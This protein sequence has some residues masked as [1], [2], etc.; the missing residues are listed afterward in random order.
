M[1][2][3]DNLMSLSIRLIRQTP[4]LIW[5]EAFDAW[6]STLCRD[7]R[8]GRQAQVGRMRAQDRVLR[9][10]R[11]R[12]N[13]ATVTSIHLLLDNLQHL[14]QRVSHYGKAEAI[15]DHVELLQLWVSFSSIPSSPPHSDVH[16]VGNIQKTSRASHRVLPFPFSSSFS[17][18]ILFHS[19]PQISR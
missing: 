1:L 18:N 12:S 8:Q 13:A 14:T 3:E 6:I 2:I 15:R 10:A 9:R 19:R 11:F 4:T 7:H 5:I 17:W 16:K